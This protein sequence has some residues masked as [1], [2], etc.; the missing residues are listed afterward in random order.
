[1]E[2]SGLESKCRSV[3]E[4]ISV[5]VNKPYGPLKTVITA[6]KQSLGQ[7]NMFTGVCLS[8]GGC[9]VPG[10]AWSRGCMVPGGVHGPRGVHR[11]G[12]CM[13]PGGSWSR[14]VHGHWGCAWSW[15]MH[16]LGGAQSR[17]RWCIV[18][19]WCLVDTPRRL[20]LLAVRI[21]LECI[22]VEMIIVLLNLYEEEKRVCCLSKLNKK[23]HHSACPD[24]CCKMNPVSRLNRDISLKVWH[25]NV[26]CVYDVIN[27][28]CSR[29][30]YAARSWEA[31]KKSQLFVEYNRLLP[32]RKCHGHLKG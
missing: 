19:G 10:G 2:P 7:G 25:S 13:V 26:N 18:P 28:L 22:L 17:W 29:F 24:I 21:L 15:G 31:I 1:M 32:W 27:L 4:S 16:G 5:N 8:T 3:P 9:M 14:G 12:G 30:H 11:P 6:R 23:K 20:L